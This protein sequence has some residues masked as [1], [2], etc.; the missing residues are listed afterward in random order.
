M[1]E[2]VYAYDMS[3]KGKSIREIRAGIEHGD[4]LDIGI[5]DQNG[6]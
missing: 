5:G 1:K 2:V 3:R 4:W 6:N